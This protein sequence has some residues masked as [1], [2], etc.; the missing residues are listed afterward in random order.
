MV[1]AAGFEESDGGFKGFWSYKVYNIFV[2]FS[3]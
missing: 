2:R 1:V 3:K